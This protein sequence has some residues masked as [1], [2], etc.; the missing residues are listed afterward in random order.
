[1]GELFLI[2]MVG[3]LGT[4]LDSEATEPELESSCL[5]CF[6]FPR[7]GFETRLTWFQLVSCRGTR[8]ME[9]RGA[10]G[11]RAGVVASWFYFISECHIVE[12][13]PAYLEEEVLV[14]N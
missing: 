9:V 10:D 2:L 14:L 13:Q 4:D 5:S 12:S 8:P 1:M 6:G 7:S 11:Y 3:G